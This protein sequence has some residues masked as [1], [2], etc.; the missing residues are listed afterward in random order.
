[1][2]RLGVAGVRCD[3]PLSRQALENP[4]G[5][6]LSMAGGRHGGDVGGAPRPVGDRKGGQRL[7]LVLVQ[8]I[9][10]PVENRSQR[11]LAVAVAPGQGERGLH[12]AKRIA[13][14][15]RHHLA[16]VGAAR[17]G[18]IHQVR[19]LR[20]GEWREGDLEGGEMTEQ[21][22]QPVIRQRCAGAGEDAHRGRAIEDRQGQGERRLVHILQIIDDHQPWP[23][24]G[25]SA[26][27]GEHALARQRRPLGSA[28]RRDRLIADYLD[29]AQGAGAKG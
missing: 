7:P 26:D 16:G 5:G 20:G 8:A 18:Q 11:A 10:A 19:D 6:A 22:R 4:G 1:V 2:E 25:D 13:I 9:K 14:R 23:C 24:T 17:H 15:D 29:A 28:H 27:Q 3:Q 12:G 21:A